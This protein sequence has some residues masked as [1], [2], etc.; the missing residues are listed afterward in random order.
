VHEYAGRQPARAAFRVA[1][2]PRTV[3]YDTRW[4]GW[5]KNLKTIRY[6]NNLLQ[7]IQKQAQPPEL[8]FPV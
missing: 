7:L 3:R 5:I 1:A 4:C 6:K 2:T 8:I